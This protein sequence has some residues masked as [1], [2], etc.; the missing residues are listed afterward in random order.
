MIEE[1]TIEASHKC[2]LNCLFCSSKNTIFDIKDDAKLKPE[3]IKKLIETFSPKILRW[4][5]GEPFIYLNEK[6]LS[7]ASG[8]SQTV[9][10]N[11]MFP[12]KVTELAKYFSEIRVSL[13]GNQETHEILTQIP[14]S[15]N[16]AIETINLLKLNRQNYPQT[17]I[18]ITSPFISQEQIAEVKALAKSLDVKTRLTGLAPNKF[19][20]RPA[21]TIASPICSLGGENCRF[22]QKRL[23]LPNGQI[24]HCAVEKVN[25][26]CPYFEINK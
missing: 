7:A 13:L 1:L 8:C 22:A 10:T 18:I 11:G 23:V 2:N 14:G 24:I 5:G 3:E 19:I 26:K 9:T 15:F 25:L 6:Y 16:K 20:S 12:K 21:G 17:Q 4:S